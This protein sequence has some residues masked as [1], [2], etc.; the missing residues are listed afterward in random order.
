[1]NNKQLCDALA[2]KLVRVTTRC[3]FDDA[4]VCVADMLTRVPFLRDVEGAR[5]KKAATEEGKEKSEEI[6][7]R[8]M[9]ELLGISRPQI[10][11]TLRFLRD[12]ERLIRSE[13]LADGEYYFIDYEWFFGVVSLRL[14][15]MQALLD[16]KQKQHKRNTYFVCPRCQVQPMARERYPHSH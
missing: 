16:T 11:Q 13:E 8:P 4:V 15:K 7:Q 2:V 1:M 5:S 6:F 12:T 10:R 9:E 3:F 14:A